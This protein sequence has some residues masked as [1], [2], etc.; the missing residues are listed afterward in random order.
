MAL[1]FLGFP[2]INEVRN[3]QCGVVAATFPY[4]EDDCTRCD[5]ALDRM[6]TFVELLERYRDRTQHGRATGLRAAASA[7]SRDSAGATGRLGLLKV[8]F[9]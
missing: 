6:S 9:G 2:D 8:V 7:G 4:C 1:K 5:R 3:Y